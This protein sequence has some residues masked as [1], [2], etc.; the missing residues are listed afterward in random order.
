MQIADFASL[1]PSE[2]GAPAH[3]AAAERRVTTNLWAFL[4]WLA[5]TRGVALPGW[6]GLCDWAASAPEAFAA[7]MADFAGPAGAGLDSRMLAAWLLHAD[8][9]PGDRLALAA[10]LTAAERAVPARFA[11]VSLVVAPSPATLWQEVAAARA[12]VLVLPLGLLDQAA[13]RQ[14]ARADL[15]A[16][17]L[18]L[19]LGGVPGAALRRRI[20]VWVRPDL[21]L[22][23]R[24]GRRCWGSPLD[25]LTLI[26]R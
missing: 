17:R 7:A 26:A 3:G 22:L 5:V 1:P 4:Y 18:I 9:R 15:S 8:L 6:A 2:C 24:R 21:V 19:V 10:T 13:R 20:G 25:P 12:S 16:L 23:A 11:A 14:P